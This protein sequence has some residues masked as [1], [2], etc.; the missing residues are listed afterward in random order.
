M[1]L[2]RFR[3]RKHAILTPFPVHGG[4]TCFSITKLMTINKSLTKKTSL[5]HYCELS[6]MIICPYLNN[7]LAKYGGCGG[8]KM[9][10]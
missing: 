6:K 7:F 9:C 3:E 8:K 2:T 4:Q 5:S 10:E 1:E